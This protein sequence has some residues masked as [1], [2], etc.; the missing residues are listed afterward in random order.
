MPQQVEVWAAST[1]HHKQICSGSPSLCG[2]CKGSFK[3]AAKQI[4][5]ACLSARPQ[6]ATP[7]S[8]PD[9]PLLL[10]DL[11]AGFPPCHLSPATTTSLLL[12]GTLPQYSGPWPS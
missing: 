7:C 1:Q 5:E 4:S 6:E 2:I 12:P 9:P 3:E 8:L 11:I 10:A